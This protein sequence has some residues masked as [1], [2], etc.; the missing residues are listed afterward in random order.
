VKRVV[1]LPGEEFSVWRGDLWANG[2]RLV[3]PDGLN[4]E[5]RSRLKAWDFA[6]TGTRA[7]WSVQGR[8]AGVDEWLPPTDALPGSPRAGEGPVDLYLE[9]DAEVPAR[10]LAVLHLDRSGGEGESM[11]RTHWQ[12]DAGRD[13]VRLAETLGDGG[14]PSELWREPAPLS[15]RLTLRLAVVD[16][17]V[18][19][20]VGERTWSGARAMPSDRAAFQFALADGARPLA[21]RLDQDL[22]YSNR[23]SLAV[24]GDHKPPAQNPSVHRHRIPDDRVF[25]MGDNTAV[26]NDSR[27]P[28]VGDIAV[29]KLVGPVVFRIWP[30]GRLGSVR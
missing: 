28:E 19:A 15:G 26:S 13:G 30:V 22:H 20:S 27:F 11:T 3:K 29:Q 23:G 17:V 18:H 6:A 8:E 21:F 12:L 5:L 2:V 1:G 25:F 9:L 16:G 14:A 24:S 7:G 4:A 10:G